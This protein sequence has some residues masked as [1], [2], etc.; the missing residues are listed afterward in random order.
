VGIAVNKKGHKKAFLKIASYTL[1][2]V[3]YNKRSLNLFFTG[4]KKF[5]EYWD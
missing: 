4:I 3:F 1:N 5:K 2:A